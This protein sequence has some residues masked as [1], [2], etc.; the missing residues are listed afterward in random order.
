MFKNMT[1]SGGF[2]FIII[3]VAL[4]MIASSFL[5]YK[6]L[7]TINLRYHHSHKIVAETGYLKSIIIGGLLF[8]SAS[9]VVF[10]NPNSKKAKNSMKKGIDKIST[11]MSKLKKSNKELYNKI[12]V[13]MNVLSK[14]YSWNTIVNEYIKLYE[15]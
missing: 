10:M 3:T 4:G 11:F 2:R 6:S 7:N 9:G 1:I 13:N 5:I 12:K 14:K 8:N 15:R